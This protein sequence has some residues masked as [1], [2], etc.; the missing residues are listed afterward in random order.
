MLEGTGTAVDQDLGQARHT[1]SRQKESGG[2]HSAKSKGSQQSGPGPGP[3]G[4]PS[5]TAMPGPQSGSGASSSASSPV[6]HLKSM[7]G[8]NFS[9]KSKDPK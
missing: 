3:G 5:V 7:F 9:S 6:K 1:T 4:V 8:M 2:A